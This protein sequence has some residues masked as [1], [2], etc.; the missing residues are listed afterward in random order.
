MVSWILCIKLDPSLF[1]FFSPPTLSLE[2]E[3]F[4]F[5]GSL[6]F[7]FYEEQI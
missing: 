5:L 2:F 4:V 3:A 1:F 6:F 7:I